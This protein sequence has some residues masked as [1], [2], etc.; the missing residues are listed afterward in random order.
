MDYNLNTNQTL[1]IGIARKVRFATMKNRYSYRYGRS[2]PNPFLEPESTINLDLNYNGNFNNKI[3]LNASIYYSY[4]TDVIQQVF[5][6]DPENSSVYQ[7]QNAGK[8]AYY[9]FDF[10]SQYSL[11]RYLSLGV[12]YN[13]IQ[14]K[15]LSN[16]DLLFLDVPNHKAN[17]FLS[18]D[19][20]GKYYFFLNSIYNSQRVSTSTGDYASD[21]FFILNVKASVTIIKYISIEAGVL[22][23]FDANYSY[24]EGYPAEGRSFIFTIRYQLQ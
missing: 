2:I 3:V 16:P 24:S 10:N 9:G 8:A 7:F 15:N 6:V 17:L 20:P 14:R 13:F 19:K 1:Q 18:Y 22:N 23:I 21:A 4:L 11:Y 5:N 12:Q